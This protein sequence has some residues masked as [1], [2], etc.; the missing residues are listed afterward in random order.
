MR[1]RVCLLKPQTRTRFHE[2]WSHVT[3]YEVQTLDFLSLPIDIQDPVAE[4]VNVMDFGCCDSEVL[5]YFA[6]LHKENC[7]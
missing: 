2:K 7:L 3:R 5:V 6:S 4:W 1:A